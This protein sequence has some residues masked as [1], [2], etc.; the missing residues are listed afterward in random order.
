M[1]KILITVG[2]VIV[3][4]GI[5]AGILITVAKR[6]K[7]PEMETYAYDRLTMAEQESGNGQSQAAGGEETSG[8][9][10]TPD[11]AVEVSGGDADKNAQE[12]TDS[13]SNAQEATDSNKN[14]Q[15]ATDS[16][17]NEQKAMDSNKNTQKI[18]DSNGSAGNSR[19]SI[20]M[21]SKSESGEKNMQAWNT[22]ENQTTEDI[23][24]SVQPGTKASGTSGNKSTEKTSQKVTQGASDASGGNGVSVQDKMNLVYEY[25]DGICVITKGSTASGNITIPDTTYHN[26]HEYKVVQIDPKAF[27][28]CQDLKSVVIGK[29]VD[30]ISSQAF[31]SCKSLTDITFPDGLKTISYWAFNNCT[32]L[33]TV[34]IPAGT[35]VDSEA[36]INCP[37]IQIQTK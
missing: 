13:N 3:S 12:A 11:S 20:G 25:G 4:L 22:A 5:V 21:D 1:K 14:A 26:G 35:S 33:K 6:E 15:E 24:V 8:S 36:F 34:L 2:M 7:A 17:K 30:T 9:E 31:Q 37:D 32:S 18:T 16:N 23:K 28:G 27:M 10:N 19:G 29:Y